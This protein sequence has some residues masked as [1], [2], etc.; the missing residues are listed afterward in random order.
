MNI[1]LLIVDPQNDFC[2]LNEEVTLPDGTVFKTGNQGTLVVPGADEDMVRVSTM[3]DRVGDKFDDIHVTLDSHRL[4]DISHPKWWKDRA[5]N[6]PAPFTLMGMDGDKIVAL[7]PQPDGTMVLTDV[8]FTTYL[9]NFLER[10]RDY[11]KALAAGG[12]YPHCIWPPHCLIGSW[13]HN[14]VPALFTALQGWEDRKFAQTNYVTKGSN[15]WTEHFSGIKAEVPDPNDPDTQV[16]T[17]LIQTLEE[18]D[19][20]IVTGEALS[21]CV[22]NTARDIADCFSDPK[23]VE[24]LCL[25]TDASSNVANFG[26]L[27]DAFM[28]E[29]LAKGMKTDTTTNFLA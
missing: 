20:V 23:Y 26:F 12:R 14:V 27:G 11:L 16:N 21:H 25:L 10:S 9:P 17:G 1:Q 28:K 18:A 24:K 22:A 4:I 6:P 7:D 2:I 5:G 15:P 19:I 13:G 3:I 8:E 29:M